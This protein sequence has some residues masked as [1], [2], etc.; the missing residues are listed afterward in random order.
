M[1]AHII[2]LILGM[3]AVTYIPR[4][5]PA[6]LI[7]KVRFSPK[8]G[9]FLRLIPYTAMAAL[10]FPGVLTADASHPSVGIVGALAAGMLAWLKLPLMAVVIGAVAAD[11]ILYAFVL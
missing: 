1:N 8:A 4:A 3:A 10:I 7:E 2:I 11:M 6:V 5:L 9:K